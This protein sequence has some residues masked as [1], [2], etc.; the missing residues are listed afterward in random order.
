V[1]QWCSVVVTMVVVGVQGDPPIATMTLG[2]VE[3]AKKFA[4]QIFNLPIYYLFTTATKENK[5]CLTTIHLL[6]Y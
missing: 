3:G 1:G 4:P 2:V 6:G 5:L